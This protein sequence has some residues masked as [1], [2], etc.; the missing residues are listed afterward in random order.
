MVGMTEEGAD[1]EEA[2]HLFLFEPFEVVS[3]DVVPELA[4]K[5]LV[6]VVVSVGLRVGDLEVCAELEGEEE[7]IGGRSK[8]KLTLR[9]RP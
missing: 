3:P 9:S 8:G 2:T 1:V 4:K 6:G 5:T 7:E